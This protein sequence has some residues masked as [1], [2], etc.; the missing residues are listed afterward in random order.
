MNLE[1]I[2]LHENANQNGNYYVIFTH[3]NS[4]EEATL[5]PDWQALW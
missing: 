1:N 5:G 2:I 3:E 4:H